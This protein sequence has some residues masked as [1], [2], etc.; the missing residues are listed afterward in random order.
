MKKLLLLLVLQNFLFS[1]VKTIDVGILTTNFKNK[2]FISLAVKVFEKDFSKTL[3]KE[4]I[5]I[6]LYKKEA[7]LLHDFTNNKLKIMVSHPFFYFDNK[8]IIDKYQSYIWYASSNQATTQE[9]YLIS[10]ANAKN[11]LQNVSQYKLLTID[12]DANSY[13]WFKYLYYKKFKKSPLLRKHSVLSKESKIIYNVFF[14]PNTLGVITKT[15]YE[16][17]VELN[18][19]I[20]YK[21]KII[22]KSTAMFVQLMGF[23]HN[24]LNEEESI[25]LNKAAANLR[26]VL[27][28]SQLSDFAAVKIFLEYT[29]NELE[30]FY[31]FYKEYNNLRNKYE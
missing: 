21:T 6:K 5:K 26:D 28:A 14:N 7:N 23:N 30:R 15:A 2:D 13:I 24:N 20:K 1:S 11:V 9:Y 22:K 27:G 4:I 18:P 19:Q 25:L 31:D 10:H 3:N 16:L 29:N 12:M 8:K 17:M